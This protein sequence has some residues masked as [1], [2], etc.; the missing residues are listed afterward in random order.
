[1]ARYR[2]ADYH[3]ECERLISGPE[4]NPCMQI[5]PVPRLGEHHRVHSLAVDPW[6]NTWFSVELPTCR[7][8]NAAGT[9][10]DEPASVGF[11]NAAW[12]DLVYF[13]H[14]DFDTPR[15][16]AATARIDPTGRTHCD[17]G[18]D[19]D[20]SHTGITTDLHGDTFSVWFT[21][22]GGKIRQLKYLR[23]YSD[24]DIYC[25]ITNCK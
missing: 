8:D 12:N 5:M 19:I 20:W 25:A 9:R 1:M 21:D 13:D 16:R 23:P 14:L 15:D 22:A 17:S 24:G 18:Q 7:N 6:G 4:S 2:S 10:Y 3:G 11:V